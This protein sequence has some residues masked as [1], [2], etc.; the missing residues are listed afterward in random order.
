M[1]NIIAY[2]IGLSWNIVFNTF[3]NQMAGIYLYLPILYSNKYLVTFSFS[4][5]VFEFLHLLK[6]SSVN[7]GTTNGLKSFLYIQHDA[8]YILV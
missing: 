3:Q 6:F 7:L 2:S 4:T 5:I 1:N 8:S